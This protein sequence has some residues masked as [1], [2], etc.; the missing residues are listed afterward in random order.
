MLRRG[1]A[2]Q[3]AEAL[4]RSRRIA[5]LVGPALVAITMSEALN[6]EVVQR[7]ARSNSYLNGS[8]L[9]VAGLS[10]VRAHNWWTRGWPLTVTLT[11]WAG[12]LGGLFRMFAPAAEMGRASGARSIVIAVPFAVGVFL[13]VMAVRP[14]ARRTPAEQHPFSRFT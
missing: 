8:V 12:M 6:L 13:T 14:A 10:I 9:F 1:S 11:G 3:P 2:E 4:E 7:Q 5:G